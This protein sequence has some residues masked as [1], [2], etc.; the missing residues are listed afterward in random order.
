MASVLFSTIGQAVGGPLGA[1]VGAALGATVDGALFRRGRGANQDLYVQRSAYGAIVPHVFGTARV[2][3]QM[4]WAQPPADGRQSKG[5][6]RR[7][8]SASFAIALSVGPIMSIG[9]IW[10]DGREFRNSEGAFASPTLMRICSKGSSVDPLIAAAEGMDAAPAFASLSYVVLEELDLGAFGNRIPNLSFE[11]VA[12]DGGVDR[13]LSVLARRISAPAGVGPDAAAVDGYLA[14][15]DRWFDDLGV[16]AQ[17]G[18][19]IAGLPEGALTFAANPSLHFIPPDDLL[20]STQEQ[21][22]LALATSADRPAGLAVDYLD[23]A[24][25]YQVGRQ[26]VSRARAGRQV[27]V[28]WSMSARSDV[29]RGLAARLLRAAEARSDRISIGLSWRWLHVA[30]GDEIHLG[31]SGGWRVT[32]KDVRG[33]AIALEAERLP[34]SRRTPIL[35]A[36]SGRALLAPLAVATPTRID[37]FE[38]PVSPDG[39]AAAVILLGSGDATWRGAEARLLAGGEER[40]LGAFAPSVANGVLVDHLGPGP[41]TLWDEMS[42]VIVD[43]SAG[44]DGFEARSGAEV[45]AGANLVQVGA[46][47][48]QYRAAEVIAPDR[49]RLSGLLR[50]R[51][52]TGLA[53]TGAVAGARVVQVADML[54]SRPVSDE[55]IGREL[56]FLAV[57]PGDATGGTELTHVV[58]G[59]GLAPLAP[60]HVVCRR[61]ADGTLSCRWISRHRETWGWTAAPDPLPPAYLWRLVGDDAVVREQRVE[62]VSV[63]FDPSQQ[64]G[65]F[66]G[67]LPAGWVQVVAMGSGPERVRASLPVRI[68]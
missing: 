60:A 25:D 48:L 4:I 45:L 7:S 62:G 56:L 67:V 27:D 35:P 58:E 9:R 61:L 3:G 46:E 63:Q 43:T 19:A 1:G 50:G 66:G 17:L 53:L 36:D 28:S 59:S 44:R 14:A 24:R 26:M 51:F 16:V 55:M 21:A 12:D 33:L 5:S 20:S 68:G 37:A 41:A 30:V 2:A 39:A 57:G 34:E 10:A 31:S 18:G 65:L 42:V 22:A 47:L 6:G 23:A 29:A 40:E 32:R 13:W 15:S 52:G 8:V 38:F 64:L 49:V 11:V 54:P